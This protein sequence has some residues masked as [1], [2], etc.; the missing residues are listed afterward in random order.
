MT[1]GR[2]LAVG[3]L[4]LA[5][6]FALMGGEYGVLDHRELKQLVAVEED[7]IA[8][9]EQDVDSLTGYL[10]AILTDPEVQERI[11]RERLG[12]VRPGEFVYRINREP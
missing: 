8:V 6:F 2:W 7:S 5:L 1:P 3:V 11:A 10:K 9:L 4:V 12:M